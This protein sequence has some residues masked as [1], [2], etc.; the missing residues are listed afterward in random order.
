MNGRMLFVLTDLRI[1][2]YSNSR[3]DV[4]CKVGLACAM[5]CSGEKVSEGEAEGGQVII[6]EYR[7]VDGEEK[8]ILMY[9]RAGLEEEKQ[10]NNRVIYHN[11]YRKTERESSKNSL[12]DTDHK[13]V[14]SCNLT[15]NNFLRGLFLGFPVLN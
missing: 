12:T 2:V 10:V 9:V 15:T 13:T 5:S 14:L 7:E 6:C 1:A 8:P 3:N 11:L 4:V